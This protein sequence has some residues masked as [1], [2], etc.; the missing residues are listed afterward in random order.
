MKA[1]LNISEDQVIKILKKED[2]NVSQKT[3][4]MV[5]FNIKRGSPEID[6]TVSTFY[7]NWIRQQAKTLKAPVKKPAFSFI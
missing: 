4:N 3:I 6:K 1:A 5:L 7:Y 2:P